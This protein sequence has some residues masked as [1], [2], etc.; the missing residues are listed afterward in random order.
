MCGSNGSAVFCTRLHTGTGCL[1]LTGVFFSGTGN[2]KHCVEK[3]IKCFD[4]GKAAVPIEST[5]VRIRIAE[6][7]FIVFGYPIYFSNI[8]KIVRGF[9]LGN[10]DCFAGKKVFLLATMGLFSGDGAGCSARLLKKS[11]AQIVGGLHV[12]MPDC[13]GDKKLLKKP[14]EEN[15]RIVREADEKIRLAAQ[16]LKD[17]NPA[18]DGLNPFD[19]MAGLFGQRLWFYGETA[20]YQKKPDIDRQ[21]CTGCGLC[22]KLCPMK[23]LRLSNGKAVSGEKCTLC[24]RCFSRCPVRALTI[25]GK[26]VFEQCLFEDYQ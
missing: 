14:L 9:I 20:S 16:R 19:H 13:I 25:L 12:K 22:V 4:T 21:K 23:N 6:D 26:E 18:K 10:G 8:P 15:K 3:F 11:G 24:Y 1:H 7:E 5:D 2:T 17:G